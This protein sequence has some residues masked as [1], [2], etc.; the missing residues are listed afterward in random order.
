[1]N[2]RMLELRKQAVE[3]AFSV[4]TLNETRQQWD[5][6]VTKKLVELIAKECIARVRLNQSNDEITESWVYENLVEDF[7]QL[8]GVTE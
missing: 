7:E 1:M 2:E 5:E 3:N 4:T 8:F 6:L